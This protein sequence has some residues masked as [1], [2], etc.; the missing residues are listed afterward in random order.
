[1]RK[2]ASHVNALF[3]YAQD[4]DDHYPMPSDSLRQIVYSRFSDFYKTMSYGKHLISVR[5][6]T[7]HG[8]FYRS[9][10]SVP[11]YKK[12]YDRSRH[13]RGF[14]MFNEEILKQVV[15]DKGEKIFRNVDVIIVIGTDGGPDWY[16]PRV[17]ATGFGMLGV[18]FSAGH[19]TFGRRQR[20]GGITVEIGSD[21]G[22]AAPEDDILYSLQEILW[23]LA[24]EY[25]HWLG[26]GHRREREGVYALMAPKLYDNARMPQFGPPPLDIF[27]IIQL[28]WL[29]EKNPERVV[30]IKKKSLAQTITLK[31]IRSKTG[32]VLARIDITG[33]KEKFYVTYHRQ[34]SNLFDGAYMGEG[35]L[36][37]HRRGGRIDVECAVASGRSGRDHLDDGIDLGGR[38][39]DFFNEKTQKNFTP[40]TI[41][42]SNIG[43]RVHSR[44]RRTG[45][46]IENIHESASSVSFSVHF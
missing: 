11:Y 14:G 2:P 10:F 9:K 26:L 19:K 12:H 40:L 16:I 23:T 4:A 30:V 15:K 18:D 36:I 35:V 39:T 42:N 3:I 41:P 25:G 34:N 32:P 8:G 29:D 17:N 44:H 21:A 22:T 24:H 33:S 46:S 28:G 5:E 20:Q 38:A 27:H 6:V 37:W 7:N 31:E 43:I 1:M 13:V 45:I